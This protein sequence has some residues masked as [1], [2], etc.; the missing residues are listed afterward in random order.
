MK[1]E[2]TKTSNFYT[3]LNIGLIISALA[4][5]FCLC[6]RSDFSEAPLQVHDTITIIQQD[7]F[8]LNQQNVYK[9]LCNLDIK[10][11][12][13]VLAQSLLETGYYTSNICIKNHNLFGFQTSNGYMKF[14]TYKDCIQ[15]YKN[16]QNSYYKGGNYYTFLTTIGYAEDSC[17]IEKLKQMKVDV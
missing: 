2:I 6:P 13:I 9:E 1:N 12:K 7:T 10:Y 8:V 17:Y 4:I 11:S 16:W 5:L 3:V 15:K 14:E